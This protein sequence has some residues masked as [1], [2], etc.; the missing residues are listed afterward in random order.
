MSGVG[1]ALAIVS[2][3]AGL[4]QAYDA[5][6]RIVRQIKARRQAHDALPPTDRLEETIEN[7]KKE[8]EQVLAKGTFDQ[9]DTIAIIALLKITVDT[10]N[11]LLEG[12]AQARVDD[13]IIDFEECIDAS[14]QN[15]LNAVIELQ[16]LERRMLAQEIERKRHVL[17]QQQQEETPSQT[18][19][20]SATAVT[21]DR[22]P[23]SQQPRAAQPEQPPPRPLQQNGRRSSALGRMLRRRET[24]SEIDRSSQ[25]TTSS[26]G[27]L[28]N[29]SPGPSQREGLFQLQDTPVLNNSTSPWSSPGSRSSVGTYDSAL[30]PT[31][32]PTRL[33]TEPGHVPT[34]SRQSTALSTMSAVSSLSTAST[35]YPI[36]NF[37]GF[38]KYAHDLRGGSAKKALSRILLGTYHTDVAY[39]CASTKCNFAAKALK[40]N[41]SYEID[42]RIRQY[43]DG[44]RYR[45]LFLA[46]SH[47]RQQRDSDRS[48]FRCMICTMLGDEAGL[49]E[50]SKNLLA[51]VATHQ[52]VSLGGTQLQ[53][54]MVFSNHGAAS[55]SENDFDLSLSQPTTSTTAV[56]PRQ[57]GA[58]VVVAASVAMNSTVESAMLLKEIAHSSTYE[59][60][61]D[62]E[63]PWLSEG[64]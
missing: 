34:V 51:H 13:S 45:W 32:P 10:Q 50:G 24:N 4:I 11:A 30:Q 61:D 14:A 64:R 25:V 27:S 21:P 38:C 19:R 7:G 5:G 18:A 39:K 41:N 31:R 62:E 49:F 17:Q 23:S 46:K 22:Q 1:E 9:G 59:P 56:E 20:A 2:C 47:V 26:A 52:G 40:K 57:H 44:V 58:A 6:A 35:V 3:V 36:T 8:I 15:R 53:G 16:K 42:D 29:D 55:A 28:P 37:G 60:Y 54:P 48:L 43:A 33:N 12:L 63:N